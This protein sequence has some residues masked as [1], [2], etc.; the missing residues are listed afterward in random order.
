MHYVAGMTASAPLRMLPTFPPRLDEPADEVVRLAQ[1]GPRYTS[2]PPAT[3]FATGFGPADAA[4]EL[5]ALPDEPIAL[6]GH[7]PFCSQLCWYCGCNVI[8][9]R[10][11]SRGGAY[12]DLLTRELALVTAAIGRRPRVNDI[13]LGGGSPNFLTPADLER[14]VGALH[15]HVA[16]EPGAELGVELD[17]RDT[18]AEQIDR[19]TSL[20]FT[21]VSVGVQDFDPGVQAAIHRLQSVAQ[22][23]AVVEHARARGCRSVNVDLIYGLPGQTV[24]SIERTLAEVVALAPD[25]IAVFGYAHLPHLRPHQRLVARSSPVPELPARVEL[26]RAVLARLADAGYQ[27]VGLD[28]FARPGD[29]LLDAV[30]RGDLGRNFQGYVIQRARALV[31]I[32][33]SAISDGGSAY[34][35]N[36][37][38]L[39]EWTAAIE[40]GQLP[41]ARGVALDHD[42]QVRRFVIMRLMCEGRLWFAEVED[43][44][45]VQFA[46]TFAD[47]LAQLEADASALAVVDRQAGTITATP[48]GHHLIRNVARVFDRYARGSVAGSPSI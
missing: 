21:R 46:S 36:H 22:T 41:V 45:H 17:P 30:E 4:R 10:D 6:Y 5:A 39:P 34:W 11:R 7:I 1:P 35:Q 14:L 16:I 28:H 26:L 18:T 13:A 37:V 33:A 15:D 9:T 40:A 8:A 31:G 2:Y 43:L 3:Q 42:D 44:H 23:R 25:R 29:P 19:L 20:G 48:L 47:E 12:L 38:D 27:R 24:A 32:G